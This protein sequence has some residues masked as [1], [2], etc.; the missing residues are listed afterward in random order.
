MVKWFSIYP[1]INQYLIWLLEYKYL[2]DRT[3]RKQLAFFL[4]TKT[5]HIL[6]ILASFKEI[7]KKKIETKENYKYFRLKMKFLPKNKKAYN[8]FRI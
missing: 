6:Y 7:I 3:R 1:Y 2:L 4:S 8:D 5:S